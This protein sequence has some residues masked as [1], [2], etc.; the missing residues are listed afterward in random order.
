[1][2]NSSEAVESKGKPIVVF[3]CTHNRCRSQMAEGIMKYLYKNNVMVYSA[4]S[5]PGDRVNPKAIESL[6]ELNID[7]SG[8]IPKSVDQLAELIQNDIKAE[9]LEEALDSKTVDYVIT[10]CS[11]DGNGCPML[12]NLRVKNYI[13]HIFTDPSSAT[14]NND[15]EEMT[16]FR[17][18][19]TEI[20]DYLKAL[21]INHLIVTTND[22]S[23]VD[24]EQHQVGID[25]DEVNAAVE[26][27]TDSTEGIS[28]FEKYLT[29]WV[30]ICMVIGTLIG[31]FQP[32]IVDSLKEAEVYQ[33]SLP[34]GILLWVMIFPMLLQIDF[35]SVLNA[36]SNPGPIL[37]T[38]IVNFAIQPFTMYVIA[39]IFFR[40]IY[41]TVIPS[42]LAN[43]YLA[44][45][46][47]LGGAPCTA[48]VFVWSVLLGGDPGY[49][50]VQVAVNDAVM[51]L[52]YLPTM[53]LLLN[54]SSIPL[55]YE[56]IATS[57]A[58][59]IA[60]PLFLAIILR[61]VLV[62]YGGNSLLDRTINMLKPVCPIGLLST[63]VLI[64]IYQGETI[65]Q[66]PLHILLII[67]PLALQT[68]IIFGLTFALGYLVCMEY[69]ILSPAALISTSNF[70]EL[71]VAIAIS[72]YG[73]DS[74]ASLATVVGVLVEVPLMLYLV[75]LCQKFRPGLDKRCS[76]CDEKC[77]A[78]RDFAR[79]KPKSRA[80]TSEASVDKSTNAEYS[81]VNISEKDSI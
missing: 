81:M 2:V 24:I 78:L 48:M 42:D 25:I 59:F 46:I 4:G 71:A 47:L 15:D 55:P 76:Q 56:V 64:F 29:V 5:H 21:P 77:A 40:Y 18:V 37:L 32:S 43:E 16:E 44:G 41:A 31:Y 8:N 51:L 79:C 20:M 13:H 69:T 54:A 72:I 30:L 58:F 36:V 26:A 63:L 14:Y 61:K 39:F 12:P 74:G 38:T 33:I 75:S 67:I 35:N 45:C 1:M 73:P 62:A 17:R 11:N 10:L 65:G 49:T 23:Q 7:L 66:K 80:T 57:V 9:H 6:K 34:I 68:F 70:F 22:A 60:I 3:L 50:I 52:L 53:L 28:F 19:R 27:K